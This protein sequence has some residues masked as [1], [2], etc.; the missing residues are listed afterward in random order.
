MAASG[1]LE[2]YR[3]RPGFSPFQSTLPPPYAW[4]GNR[5]SSFDQQYVGT[6]YAYDYENRLISTD[7][8]CAYTYAPTGERVTSACSGSTTDLAY[9]PTSGG[10][11]LATYTPAG[12][13]TAR[14]LDANGLNTPVEVYAGGAH[15]A[16]ATDALG[17]VRMLT[18][19]TQNVT[20]AYAYDAWGGTTTSSGSLANPL[21]YAAAVVDP[22]NS[23]YDMGARV[24]D[25]SSGGGHRFLSADPMGGGYAYAGDSPANRDSRADR[26]A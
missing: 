25:P 4:K 1:F 24:Y 13:Q 8:G 6:S 7:Q 14:Y 26:T 19:G 3:N 23:L 22:T 9:D 20:D 5:A 16:Y 21:Q 2:T 10:N 18:G 15:Y 17:S 12:T 11:L